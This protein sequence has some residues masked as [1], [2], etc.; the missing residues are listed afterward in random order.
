MNYYRSQLAFLSC[1]GDEIAETLSKNVIVYNQPPIYLITYR[2]RK[3]L[4]IVA[5]M[6]PR[7]ISECNLG[8]TRLGL[9]N[10][11]SDNGKAQLEVHE[12]IGCWNTM[13]P[14]SYK[15]NSHVLVTFSTRHNPQ[16]TSPSKGAHL[17]YSFKTRTKT[18]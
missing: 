11:E 8:K 10:T 2:P 16:P 15:R 4:F 18:V 7:K 1:C 14:R 5:E 13:V 12:M 6:R 17:F 9:L 3:S